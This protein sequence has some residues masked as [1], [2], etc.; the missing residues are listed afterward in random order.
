[1]PKFTA[2]AAAAAL[3]EAS[4]VY[5]PLGFDSRDLVTR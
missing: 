5:A 1:M 4:Q 2:A 3:L